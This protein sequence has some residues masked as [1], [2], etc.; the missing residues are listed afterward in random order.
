V[1][2]FRIKMTI[3]IGLVGVLVGSFLNVVIYR[4]PLR[5][6]IVSPPSACAEC[7]ARIKGYDNIPIL[8]WFILRGKCRSCEAVISVRYPIVE[9]STGMFFGIVAWKFNGSA[10][11]L[12]LA[13]LYLAAVSIALALIDLDT[14]T[15]PNRIVIPSFIVGIL[16]LGT[17]G[18]IDNNHGAIWRAL[19]GMSALSLFYFGAALI[20]PGGMGMGDV[21]FAGGLGLFLGYLGWDV[22]LVGAFSAFVLGGFFAL[23][24]IV[25]RK[26]S[27]TS[28]IPFGPWM[29]TGA[30]V[31]VFFSTS[32]VQQYLSLFGISIRI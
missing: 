29:L 30:W 32:I 3:I 22:L 20:Y 7:G 24:L 4:I 23:A 21:K 19:L 15:L 11:S 2:W 5:R 28:G 14:H 1:I 13:F 12:L 25:L 6:S 31:G 27:R 9:L 8:S 26:A 17:T 10:L 18:L 16:L